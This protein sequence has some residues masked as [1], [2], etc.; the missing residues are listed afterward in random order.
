MNKIYL[1]LTLSILAYGTMS[2]PATNRRI[3][4]ALVSAHMEVVRTV[5]NFQTRTYVLFDSDYERWNEAT[6]ILVGKFR[7]SV[8]NGTEYAI[9]SKT[10]Q[11]TVSL[12]EFFSL[13]KHESGVFRTDSQIKFNSKI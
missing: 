12:S 6:T 9:L 11:E 5:S 13:F 4:Q 2:D 8:L 10:F 7:V 3:V 1:F